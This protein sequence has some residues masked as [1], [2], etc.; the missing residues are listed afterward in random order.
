[1]ALQVLLGFRV[2]MVLRVL[3]ETVEY[4][5]ILDLLVQREL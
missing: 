3:L 5:V 1:M 2:P 4:P